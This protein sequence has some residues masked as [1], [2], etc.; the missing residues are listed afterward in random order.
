MHLYKNCSDIPLHNFNVVYNTNDLK[1]LIVGYNGYDEV[2][3]PKGANER[4]NEI[5]NEW[6]KLL[7]NSTTAYYYNLLQETIYLQTRYNAVRALLEKI[8]VRDDIQG[9]KLD[10]Y[11]KGLALWKYYWKKGQTKEK[12]IQRLLKQQKAS[13][14]KIKLKVSELE[15]MKKDQDSD[16]EEVSVERQVLIIE[17]STGIKINPRVDSVKTWIEA[18][19]IHES[20]QEQRQKK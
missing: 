4:W 5:K 13:E 14:N 17:Q 9:A 19:K 3:P 7:G 2:T 1:F 8:F 15:E 16:G 6:V 12:N 20:I 10:E 18:C 11:S